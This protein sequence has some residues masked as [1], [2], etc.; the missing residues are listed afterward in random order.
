MSIHR[1]GEKL[2]ALRVRKGMTLKALAQALGL[3]SHSYISELE[4]GKKIPTAEFV[5]GVARLFDVSTDVL[6]KDELELP[7]EEAEAK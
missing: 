2:H 4:G 1:F 6:L 5:L 7:K 3:G